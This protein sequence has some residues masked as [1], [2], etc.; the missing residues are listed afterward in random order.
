MLKKVLYVSIFTTS[1]SWAMSASMVQT[2]P[3][4]ELGCIK[5]LGAK[6][7]QSLLNYRKSNKIEVLD[8]L[9]NVKGIGRATLKNIEED[10]KKK[11]CTTLG[12]SS[13]NSTTEKS[14]KKRKDISAK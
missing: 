14:E 5:G 11:K 9:L 13:D 8:D 3:A 12:E 1:F 7:L 2:A 6:K 4:K 10:Q